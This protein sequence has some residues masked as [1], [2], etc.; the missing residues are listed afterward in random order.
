MVAIRTG[1]TNPRGT[2]MP[3]FPFNL[4]TPTAFYECHN[5]PNCPVDKLRTAEHFTW[6]NPQA[7]T[8]RPT[9]ELSA[10]PTYD[11]PWEHQTLWTINTNAPTEGWWCLTC[12]KGLEQF[13][14]VNHGFPEPIPL[15]AW[16]GRRD[17]KDPDNTL[18]LAIHNLTVPEP[19]FKC[20]HADCNLTIPPEDLTQCRTS[21]ANP[22]QDSLYKPAPLNHNWLC[23]SHTDE[24]TAQLTRNPTLSVQIG[25]SLK[26]LLDLIEQRA[27]TAAR[28][29]RRS[30]TSPT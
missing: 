28:K 7:L 26:G 25:P 6:W 17:Q 19:Y 21:Y 24:L 23:Q 1:L 8:Y 14:T 22:S 13:A 15:Q 16:L 27:D 11:T 18:D 2:E 5:T 9:R 10:T 4:T 12:I 3:R 29:R 20:G 30:Q